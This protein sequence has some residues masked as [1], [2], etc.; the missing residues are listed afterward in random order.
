MAFCFLYEGFLYE[1][2]LYEGFLYEGRTYEIHTSA[3]SSSIVAGG[4]GGA[5]ARESG[6]AGRGLG[7]N[8]HHCEF[9]KIAVL[10]IRVRC[11]AKTSESIAVAKL[12]RFQVTP[13]EVLGIMRLQGGPKS[14][15]E[16]AA[17]SALFS[18]SATL[19]HFVTL[20]VS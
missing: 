2:F 5:G 12:P 17:K 10:L 11:N 8:E 16:L 4:V 3:R 20:R 1:G 13:G 15:H 6:P 9:G 18:T 19:A 14:R 7:I